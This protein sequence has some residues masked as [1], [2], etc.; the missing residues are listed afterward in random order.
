[1]LREKTYIITDASEDIE[2]TPDDEGDRPSSIFFQGYD[3]DGN[4]RVEGY[5]AE[6]EVSSGTKTRCELYAEFGVDSI[7]TYIKNRK[8]GY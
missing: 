1:M 6:D 2:V 7:D 8:A 5:I 4:F 3:E